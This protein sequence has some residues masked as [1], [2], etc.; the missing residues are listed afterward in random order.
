MKKLLWILTVL[1]LSLNIVC[2]AYAI[3]VMDDAADDGEWTV[4]GSAE[5][6]TLDEEEGET[7]DIAV[8]GSFEIDADR[9]A[10]AYRCTISWQNG[11]GEYTQDSVDYVWDPVTLTYAPA[12]DTGVWNEDEPASLT[13]SLV[14]YSNVSVT[15]VMSFEAAEGITCEWDDERMTAE[16]PSAA[17][18]TPEEMTAGGLA[19]E[20]QEGECFAAFHVTDGFDALSANSGKIGTATVTLTFGQLTETFSSWGEIED[21]TGGN[22]IL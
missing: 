9:V 20:A 1:V 22:S 19:G 21:G 14:N 7:V 17:T 15:A 11:T 4:S 12:E 5:K 6:D 2:G 8:A 3:R 13:V 16:I 10:A 18:G